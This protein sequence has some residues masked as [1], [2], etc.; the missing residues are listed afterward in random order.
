MP[1]AFSENPLVSQTSFSIELP[2]VSEKG[3]NMEV[4]PRNE[5]LTHWIANGDERYLCEYVDTTDAGK[6]TWRIAILSID[7]LEQHKSVVTDVEKFTALVGPMYS[8]A[9]YRVKIPD[10]T[11]GQT[12]K[13]TLDFELNKARMSMV[14]Q[15]L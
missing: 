13:D 9:R 3:K 15:M 4:I 12:I 6:S 2:V 1:F 11:D 10:G 5:K 14:I 7:S 8:N